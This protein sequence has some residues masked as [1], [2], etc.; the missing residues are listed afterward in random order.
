MASIKIGSI[1]EYCGIHKQY[2]YPRI[3]LVNGKCYLVQAINYTSRETRI[4]VAEDCL[5]E[6]AMRDFELVENE[7]DMTNYLTTQQA[8]KL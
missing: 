6:H 4:I 3:N 7:T 2:S 8:K 1:V 5:H